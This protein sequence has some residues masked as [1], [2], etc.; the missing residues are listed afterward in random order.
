MLP[1]HQ[2]IVEALA[3]EERRVAAMQEVGRALCRTLDLDELLH[4]VV[5]RVTQIMEA[6][7]SS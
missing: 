4:L 5:E 7:R 2:G 3:R 6:D 1:G